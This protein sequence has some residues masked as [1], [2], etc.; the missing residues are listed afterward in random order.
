M[1]SLKFSPVARPLN[2]RLVPPD[3]GLSLNPAPSLD[4]ASLVARRGSKTQHY[5]TLTR[6]FGDCELYVF[7]EV[8]S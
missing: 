1:R 5:R 6:L 2:N 8:R 4:L 3:Q 7:G